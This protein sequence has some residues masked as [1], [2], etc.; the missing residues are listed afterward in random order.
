MGQ[1]T[2]DGGRQVI[3]GLA[4]VAAGAAVVKV[5]ADKGL[6]G[7]AGHPADSG[8]APITAA[9]AARFLTQCTFGVTDTDILDVQTL[10]FAAWIAGQQAMPLSGSH[11]AFV[12]AVQAAKPTAKLN[13]PAFSDSFW[14]QA[15]T[16]P[17]QLRQRMK[18]A[19]S[20]IFVI[21]FADPKMDVRGAASYY[22]MLGANCFGNFRTLLELVSLHPMMGL[23]LSSIGNTKEN[24][25]TGQHP[26]QNYAREVMQLMSIGLYQLNQDGSYQ[27]DGSGALVPNYGQAD[28]EGLSK[29][30][31]GFSWYSPTPSISTFNGKP[32]D[33][34]APVMSMIPYPAFHSISSK[35]F[36]GVTI[37]PST[38]PDPAGDLK[39]A[40]D[41]IFNHP[42]V[43]PFIG[44]Q[45]I[46]RLVTSNPSPAYVSRVAAVFNDDGSGVRGNLAAV[47][48]AILVDA[49]ARDDTVVANSTFGKLREPVV[50][51]A[52][53]MRSFGATSTSGTWTMGVTSTPTVLSQS[54]LNAPSVFNFWQPAYAL[55][56]SSMA[57]LGLVA[58]EF[59]QVNEVSVAG[60]LNTLEK[61]VLTGLGAAAPG[62]TGPDITTVYVNEIPLANDAGKLLDRL[63]LL[64]LYGQMS[65]SLRTRIIGQVNIIKPG[66]ATSTPAQIASAL[67]RRTA[68]AV[69]QIMASPE[70]MAQ[71]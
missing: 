48:Q 54:V 20:Q 42:N 36:L 18:L 63:N 57:A 35:P 67:R 52:N 40:L 2:V 69:F 53:W 38:T 11:Q 14:A 41:T 34:N 31:T 32:M 59:Q 23:F 70:Y 3:A 29:V 19:L 1:N 46:Q 51:L 44:A 12:E 21:S 55:P 28:V 5:A 15:I 25:A 49:E 6:L 58:P 30:F 7:G 13:Q 64:L 68:L 61:A 9:S 50:R 47:V 8:L 45:L 39:I 16:G 33:V 71:R 37:P 62:T 26:D 43:G 4:V 27:T 10:G 56:G 22:D 24:T 66:G 65:P 60:Y 17:D